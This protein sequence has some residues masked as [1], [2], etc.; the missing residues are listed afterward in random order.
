MI[1]EEWQTFEGLHKIEM[2]NHN[3]C[4]QR[5]YY[6]HEVL[7]SRHPKLHAKVRKNHHRSKRPDIDN[8]H[9]ASNL[10]GKRDIR[11]SEDNASKKK[12]KCVSARVCV[13]VC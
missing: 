11:F 8:G 10:H 9:I 12:E 4:K 5:E 3:G 13:C 7:F 2:E 1:Q 6:E